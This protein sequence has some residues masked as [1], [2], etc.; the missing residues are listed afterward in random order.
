MSKYEFEG[1]TLE[2]Q[3]ECENAPMIIAID[4]AAGF[5]IDLPK[6]GAFHFVPLTQSDFNIVMFKM[7]NA[8]TN[9]PELSF[10]LSN[11][12]LEQLKE[13]SLLPVVG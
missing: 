8:T 13:I 4:S 11:A 6:S 2:L 9:P 12:S 7:D 10:N 5:S 1:F 3:P